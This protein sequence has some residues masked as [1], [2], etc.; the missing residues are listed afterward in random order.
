MQRFQDTS[1]KNETKKKKKREANYSRNSFLQIDLSQFPVTAL[2]SW[3]CLANS[4][5][6]WNKI[7]TD[8]GTLKTAVREDGASFGDFREFTVSFCDDQ[9]QK[10][11]ECRENRQEEFKCL[12]TVTLFE[13]PV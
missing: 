7:W 4:A 9:K 12:K 8:N 11:G 2:S 10:P 6:K 1:P 5:F 13:Q 3:H